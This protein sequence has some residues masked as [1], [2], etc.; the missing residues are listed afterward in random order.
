M[1]VVIFERIQ[2]F[3]PKL[4]VRLNFVN[5]IVGCRQLRVFSRVSVS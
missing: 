2:T 3:A 5:S 4:T 1:S